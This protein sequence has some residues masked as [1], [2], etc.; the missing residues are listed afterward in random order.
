MLEGAPFYLSTPDNGILPGHDKLKHDIAGRRDHPSH[1]SA[2]ASAPFQTAARWTEHKV[3]RNEDMLC[4]T[5]HRPLMDQA[6]RW[7][8]VPRDSQSH[9]LVFDNTY[10]PER[11]LLPIPD[12]YP[13]RPG[14]CNPVLRDMDMVPQQSMERWGR[15][16]TFSGLE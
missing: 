2:L 12:L 8:F 4:G 13:R 9:T 10:A 16:Q 1:D 11:W 14:F 5:A 3:I 15:L 7:A 6:A